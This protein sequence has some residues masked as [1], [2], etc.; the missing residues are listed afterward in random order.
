[1]PKAWKTGHPN[2]WISFQSGKPEC[3]GRANCLSLGLRLAKT[4][5]QYIG[6]IISVE[7]LPL[8]FS[9][10]VSLDWWWPC[11]LR[12]TVWLTTSTNLNFNLTPNYFSCVLRVTM[13]KCL[14]ISR[15]KSSNRASTHDRLKTLEPLFI[16]DR[17]AK[18][19]NL[20]ANRY[21]SSSKCIWFVL[22]FNNESLYTAL[23]VLE[24]TL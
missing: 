4:S 1:M 21:V 13:G 11:K 23:A 10:Y 19:F 7:Q 12:N 8:I 20:C 9:I 16:A 6:S 2:V 5:N 22:L 17:N 3:T 15:A 18:W 24:I 14:G